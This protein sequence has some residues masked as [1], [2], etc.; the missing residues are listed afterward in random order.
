MK[1][2]NQKIRKNGKKY[3]KSE[4]KWKKNNSVSQKLTK[5]EKNREKSDQKSDIQN[6]QKRATKLF[7]AC[8]KLSYKDRLSL[9]QLPTL[10]YRRFRGDMI[11]VFKI[12][13]GFY[14]ANVVPPI[15]RNYDSRSRGNSFKLKVER[16]KYDIRKFSFCNRVVNVWNALPDLVVSSS[17][18]N[19]FKNSLDRHWKCELFYYDFE[20]SPTGFV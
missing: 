17:S 10:K 4:K 14:D 13:N 2:K 19:I 18:L 11:E 7:H 9:L 12:L 15:V 8:K 16:C 20:A 1:V 5:N 6:V 3:K